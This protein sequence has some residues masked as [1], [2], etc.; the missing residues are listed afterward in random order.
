MLFLRYHL[1]TLVLQSITHKYIKRNESCAPCASVEKHILPAKS[2][3]TLSTCSSAKLVA[4]VKEDRIK[5]KESE[6]R[7]P[8][9]E[10]RLERINSEIN[11][12][13][14]QLDDGLQK[15]MSSILNTTDVNTSPHM[16][17]IFEQQKKGHGY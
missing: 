12:H 10:Q 14:I 15:S 8:Q 16:K 9:L 7:C 3:A 13:S 17:L 1:I 5:L 4:T 11:S 6:L 2:R